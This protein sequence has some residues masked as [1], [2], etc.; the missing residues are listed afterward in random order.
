ML[1]KLTY[2][3]REPVTPVKRNNLL[4]HSLRDTLNIFAITHPIVS[5][6][7]VTLNILAITHPIVSKYTITVK[8]KNTWIWKYQPYKHCTFVSQ[9]KS[10]HYGN[11][12][13]EPAW[14]VRPQGFAN[15]THPELAWTRPSCSCTSLPSCSSA[16]PFLSYQHRNGKCSP[17]TSFTGNSGNKCI[18]HPKFPSYIGNP[19][20]HCNLFSTSGYSS[21][22]PSPVRYFPQPS[23][24]N[25][26]LIRQVH[27]LGFLQYPLHITESSRRPTHIPLQHC[28]VASSKKAR[29]ITK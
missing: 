7:T 13:F 20:E 22:L 18:Q 24:Q 29:E 27:L 12:H 4:F 2:F 8:I 21:K 11:T 15:S 25:Q 28:S 5:K 16:E 17:S 9:Y 6:Y 26:N 10:K 23:L 3:L 19:K 14:L 1:N